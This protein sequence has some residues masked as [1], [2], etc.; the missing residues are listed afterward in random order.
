[1]NFGLDLANNSIRAILSGGA[2]VGIEAFMSKGGK[3]SIF[4]QEN[5]IKFGF[6]ALSSLGVNQIKSFLSPLLP[7]GVG[8]LTD[9]YVNPFI[10]AGTYTLLARF[11]S[12]SKA[13]M[14]NFMF[15]MSADM[16]AGFLEAPIKALMPGSTPAG[17][18]QPSRSYVLG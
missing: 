6:Q 9:V 4:S 12:G 13:Y 15:S 3:R 18:V 16:L 5:L 14:Y 1:M 8:A 10:V 7:S 11:V 2:L 17:A